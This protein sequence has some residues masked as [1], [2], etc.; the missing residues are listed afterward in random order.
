MSTITSTSIAPA[1]TA[2]A[3]R[4]WPT[5]VVAGLAASAATTALAAVSHAAGASLEVS[6]EMIPLLGF[7]QLTFIF[8][9]VGLLI[10]LGVR[11]WAGNP[12]Q[13]WVRSTVVLTA[14]SLIPDVLADASSAT[15]I[16]LMATHVLAAAIVIPAVAAKFARS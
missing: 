8:S 5:A 15:K 7:A 13:V 10:A 1:E 14:L 6:G 16:T 3:T 4:L 2:Q 12:R 9:M 11:R